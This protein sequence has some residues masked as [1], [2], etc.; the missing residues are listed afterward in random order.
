MC[1]F[2][3]PTPKNF[4][5]PPM[6]GEQGQT[7]CGGWE[8]AQ[9][10]E[11]RG[12]GAGHA[13]GGAGLCPCPLPIVILDELFASVNCNCFDNGNSRVGNFSFLICFFYNTRFCTEL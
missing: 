3:A 13:E 7:W 10:A 4:L 5:P 2:S 6:G 12:G 8:Q 1:A 9:T 11:Q